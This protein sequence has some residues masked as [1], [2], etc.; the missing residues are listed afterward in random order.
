M[1]SSSGPTSQVT[2]APP[3]WYSNAAQGYLNRAGEVAGQDYTPYTGQRVADLSPVTRGAIGGLWDLANGHPMGDDAVNMTRRTLQGGY[4]NPFAGAQGGKDVSTQR[5][6]FGN[7]NVQS[8]RNQFAGENPYF[9]QQLD[10]GQSK[11]ADAYKRGTSADTTRMFNL[12]GA[13]GGSAHQNAVKNNE[14]ALAEQLG[15]FTSGMLNDQ[16]QRTA[17][18][19]E[20]HLGRDFAGQ[21][22]NTNLGAQ[23]E[24]G[25]LGR[26]FAG[27]QFNSGLG[28]RAVD[29]GFQGHENERNRQMQGVGATTGLLGSHRDS[30]QAALQGGDVERNWMQGA[31]DSNYGDFR[32]WRDYDRNQLDVY[33]NALS[34]T[35]GGVGSTRTEQGPGPDRVS[36]GLGAFAAANYLGRGK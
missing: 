31:L 24:E 12:S 10:R 18:L 5:N 11:I 19:E 16:Y 15:G 28:E 25:Y 9:M 32:E 21:Q 26:D 33:G 6:S 34:R 30:L 13:F 17:G 1:G 35:A 3:A 27:Q 8:Q 7:P 20:S 36:Q 23:L 22:F 29:R 14:E 2:N 4:S